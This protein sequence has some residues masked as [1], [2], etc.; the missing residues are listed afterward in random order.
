MRVAQNRVVVMHYTL[1]D[2]DGDTI[3][4]SLGKDPLA[5]IQGIGTIIPGLEDALEG[6]TKGDKIDVTI[7][8]EDGYGERSDENVQIVP[9][10]GFQGEG[11]EELTPGMQVQVE[12]N[13]G[14][15][16]AMVTQIEGEEVTLDLNH[17][18]A[19][20]T[21]NFDVEVVDVREATE[22]EIEHGHVHGP[23]GHHH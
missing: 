8:P 21:L 18:L 14:P 16:I 2:G 6:K 4:S 20:V 19:G 22:E 5:Y 11:D 9:K 23:G 3:D 10:S 12:T 7:T 13:N 1:K 17:P 15:T